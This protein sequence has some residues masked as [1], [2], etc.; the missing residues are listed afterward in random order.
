MFMIKRHQ[1]VRMVRVISWLKGHMHMLAMEEALDLVALI[2][3]A[4]LVEILH[5]IKPG[6]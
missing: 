3:S 5:V 1:L 2:D 6:A 4:A